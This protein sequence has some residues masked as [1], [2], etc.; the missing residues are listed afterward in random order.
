MRSPWVK[1]LV[2]LPVALSRPELSETVRW[3]VS[4]DWSSQH[5]RFARDNR[6]HYLVLIF[7][8]RY[9]LVALSVLGGW[10]VYRW[11]KQLFGSTAGL[12]A[13]TLWALS[14][15]VLS[16]AGVCT[17]DLG[18]TVFGLAA[19]YAL[20]T[21]FCRPDWLSA[22]FAGW[23]FGLAQLS[24][25][26]LLVFYPVVLFVWA[27]AY[28][29][30]G[31]RWL[32]LAAF[33]LVSVLVINLGYGFRGSGRPLGAFSFRCQALRSMAEASWVRG[34]WLERLPIPLPEAFVRGLDEQKFR[35]DLQT[36]AY[37]RG[38]WRQGGWW[39]FYLY[40]AAV[41]LPLGTGL[42]AGLAV[43]LACRKARYRAAV[44]DECL[45][46]LPAA[47]IL[48]LLSSQMRDQYASVR[49][50]LPAFPFLFIGISRVGL[51]LEEGWK[52]LAQSPG[53]ARSLLTTISALLVAGALAWNAVSVLR[54][55]PHY[56]SYFN[57]WAGGPEY[58][59]QHLIESNMDWGQDL[60]FLKR[61]CEEHPEAQPLALAHYGGI[62]PHL[63]GLNYRLAPAGEPRP[64]W[65]AISVNLVC[66]APFISYGER[67]EE[68]PF[69][70]DA[71]SYFRHLTPVAKAG[72]SI[73]IYHVEAI[74][75]K[76]TKDTK[77]TQKSNR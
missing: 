3:T 25:F 11:S 15:S 73:F 72:Y 70:R 10:L 8:A 27:V 44:L 64:G 39:Y 58:G 16:W 21:C 52:R 6:D 13:L 5:D 45:L 29:R 63:V 71:Y 31:V 46:W 34:T 50:V 36:P 7:R 9:V 38:Q 19:L 56:L 20:R 47:A 61:W 75:H 43:W 62:D 1:A 57:E 54:V 51:V 68:V 26:S 55:H 40:A 42:L 67:G 49:Y 32:H 37:L 4:G 41:K 48:V 76:G 65:Y 35:A 12:I 18:A 22:V 33:L 23:V 53:A 28:W 77:E 66:G 30:G 17:V 24:K 74:H 2:A 14:P 60:L 59:W 69:P